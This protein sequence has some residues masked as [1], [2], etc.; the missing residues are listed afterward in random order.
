M[1]ATKV[2]LLLACILLFTAGKSYAQNELTIQFVKNKARLSAVQ[3][4]QLDS[5]KRLHIADS[6]YKLAVG[7]YFK[8]P[9]IGWKRL[10]SVMDILADTTR[11]HFLNREQL[12]Y[13]VCQEGLEVNTVYLIWKNGNEG[14]NMVPAPHPKYK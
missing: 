5:F 7:A 6:T 12:I 9:N 1:P 13:I 8:N 3:L 14:P 2:A 11:P 10:N 4:A